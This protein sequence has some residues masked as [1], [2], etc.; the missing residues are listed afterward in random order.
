MKG[1]GFFTGSFTIA[2]ATLFY[3]EFWSVARLKQQLPRNLGGHF[4]MMKSRPAVQQV[5]EKEGL[6]L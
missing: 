3:P 6:S 2:D 4:E 5:L 1:A